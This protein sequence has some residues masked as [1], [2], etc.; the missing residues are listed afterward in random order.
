VS[1]ASDVYALGVLLYKL[2]T[3]D[4][5]WSAD[6][7]A[8]L[9]MAHVHTEPAELPVIDGVP[10]EVADLYSR[11]MA[12]NPGD[13]PAAREVA[14]VLAV[15]AGISPPLDDASVDDADEPVTVAGPTV[16]GRIGAGLRPAGQAGT[17][18]AGG[19]QS[20]TDH[21]DVDG[22][23][24]ALAAAAR[25][26]ADRIGADR[27]GADRV[28]AGRFKAG[29]SLAGLGGARG[30]PVAVRSASM[31]H[32]G[33]ARDE[34]DEPGTIRPA[35]R[36]ENRQLA[37]GIVALIGI[38]IAAFVLLNSLGRS[39]TLSPG[40]AGG[41]DVA[42]GSSSHTAGTAPTAVATTGEVGAPPMVPVDTGAGDGASAPG[43]PAVNGAGGVAVVPPVVTLPTAVPVVNPPPGDPPVTAPPDVPT[44][45]P[46]TTPTTSPPEEPEQSTKTFVST[47]GTIVASCAGAD[48]SLLSWQPAAGYRVKTVTQGP[49][50]QV[51]VTF[52][53]TST[54]VTM[55][56]TCSAGDP[57]GTTQVKAFAIRPDP[58]V[59]ADPE[60][61]PPISGD[62]GGAQGQD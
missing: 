61:I 19:G 58:T 55:T 29:H 60:A 54:E 18:H 51:G 30:R 12:K 15:A 39:A 53:S 62:S 26:G 20:G 59:S 1:P 32:R 43:V 11:C 16:A 3:H 7:A 38:V 28:P 10:P 42:V 27:I 41:P 47:G 44:T 37:V 8:E 22:I 40:A 33:V 52:K 23:G 50:A 14:T 4:L 35:D 2:L 56:V 6:T 24:A 21:T 36:S 45:T 49:A 17:D 9:M 25:T 34:R 31:S 13:R 5:P 46:P 48:A 57:V